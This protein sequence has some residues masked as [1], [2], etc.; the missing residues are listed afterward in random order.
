MEN[1]AEIIKNVR[2]RAKRTGK[3][4]DKIA[5][6]L[7]KIYDRNADADRKD[8]ADADHIGE[9]LLDGLRKL[10]DLGNDVAECLSCRGE[11]NLQTG[12][13]I[14]DREFNIVKEIADVQKIVNDCILEIFE[15]LLKTIKTDRIHLFDTIDKFAKAFSALAK[16]IT[17]ARE[18]IANGLIEI[19]D[20]SLNDRKL[21]ELS[22]PV[23]D[24]LDTTL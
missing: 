5:K 7:C 22:G 23:L 16:V 18:N 3:K 4:P 13:E 12:T 20:R 21:H 19:R 1:V 11:V 14:L 9:L 10:D 17:K 15:D 2:H 6:L 24:K 8:L